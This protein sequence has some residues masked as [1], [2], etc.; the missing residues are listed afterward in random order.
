MERLVELAERLNAGK[1]ISLAFRGNRLLVALR[2]DENLFEGGS[3][4]KEATDRDRAEELLRELRMIY[5][6]VD[7]LDLG[8]EPARHEAPG[9]G[10]VE[11]AHGVA[12]G[13]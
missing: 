12:A 8:E 7:V 9:A 2:T 5:D 11:T 6:V 3:V 4:L 13:E 10:R 1:R